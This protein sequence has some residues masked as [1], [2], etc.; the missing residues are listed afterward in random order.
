M[1]DGYTGLKPCALCWRPFRP[2]EEARQGAEGSEA[3]CGRKE[4]CGRQEGRGAEEALAEEA[5]EVLG[6]PAL[7][8]GVVG[9]AL[10]APGE[11][12]GMDDA[13]TAFAVVDVGDDGVEHLVVDDELEEPAGDPIGIEKGV[14]ADHAILLLDGA[15]DEVGLWA[16]AASAA[17]CDGVAAQGVAKV[18]GVQLIEDGAEIVVAALAGECELA[19]HGQGGDGGLPLRLLLLARRG[20]FGA[21][22]AVPRHFEEL[23]TKWGV[24][25]GKP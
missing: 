5:G 24:P 7:G 20:R 11:L 22:M 18:A 12:L 17:P 19:L 23:K 2:R 4:G 6:F 3:G 9:E 8:A 25:G 10:L 1:L 14:D 13:A 15:E 16:E 21:Y